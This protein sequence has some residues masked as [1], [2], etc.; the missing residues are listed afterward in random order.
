MAK[1]AAK[2]AKRSVKVAVKDLRPAKASSVKG[3][4][5]VTAGYDLKKNIKA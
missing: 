3:S 2:K 1:R 4:A 5:A